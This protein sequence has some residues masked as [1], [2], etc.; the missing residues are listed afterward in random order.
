MKA[1]WVIKTQGENEENVCGGVQAPVCTC[2]HITQPQK[3]IP[4][5]CSGADGH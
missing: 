2:V 1:N 4:E 5:E 3:K